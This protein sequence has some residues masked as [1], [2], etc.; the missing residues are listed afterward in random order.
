[1]SSDAN[2][3]DKGSPRS[4]SPA[5]V[6][7]SPEVEALYDRAIVIDTLGSDRWDEAGFAAWKKS[8]Y[9]AIQTTLDANL[10]AR[11]RFE[12]EYWSEGNFEVALASLKKWGETFRQHPDK[13]VHCTKASD[14]ERA[15]REGKL[16]VML[17]FQEAPVHDDVENLDRLYAAG[18]RCIQLTYMTRNNL[19]DGCLERLATGLSWFGI[20]CV[21]KMNALGMI[22][23]V[24]HSGEGTTADAIT[25][26]KQPVAFTHT[27]CQAVYSRLSGGVWNPRAKS[28]TLLR[29][30]ADK[31]GVAGMAT[32]GYFVGPNPDTSLEHYV[33]HIAHAVRVAGINHVG[34]CTD[35]ALRGIEASGATRENWLLPRL[36]RNHSMKPRWP[37]WIPELDKPDRYRSVAHA[38]AQRGFK[39]PDIEKILGGN[40]M[41]L[42]R[43]VFRG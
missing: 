23:D 27:M 25:F 13:F 22:V 21:E 43:E 30:L 32:L 28:D 17:G 12:G 20:A 24:A 31:G 2:F 1:M 33:D 14:I 5:V 29:A 42:F 15:K 3:Q 7:R 19:G 16:A 38:L 10:K 39:G 37:P 6:Q 34:V 41:R 26:S 35:H 18:A 4:G 8:G 11:G 40:W 9:T 36:R